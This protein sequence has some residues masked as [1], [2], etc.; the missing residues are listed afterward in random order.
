MP[1]SSPSNCSAKPELR[2]KPTAVGGRPDQRGVIASASYEARKFGVRSA[3]PTRT[4][5]QFCPDL[6]LLPSHHDLYAQH[7][8]RIMTMLLEITPQIEQLSIDEAFLDITGTELRYGSAEKLAHYL[9]D[10]IRDEF[11]AAVLDRR[12]E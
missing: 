9:H 8:Q 12:G 5:L 6:I 7:S 2:G 4:A 10:R 3:M 1:S 11:R